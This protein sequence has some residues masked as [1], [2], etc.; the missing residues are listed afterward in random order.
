M[1][2]R[3]R[4]NGA[5]RWCGESTLCRQLKK[6]KSVRTGRNRVRFDHGRDRWLIFTGQRWIPDDDGELHRLAIEA[7]RVRQQHTLEIDE[8]EKRRYAM[9]WAM[10]GESRRRIENMLVL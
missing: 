9:K 8:P 10:S 4:S 3:R 6:P 7:M 2:F 1:N 5:H